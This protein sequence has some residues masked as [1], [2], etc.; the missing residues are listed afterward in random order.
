MPGEIANV[1]GAGGI[2]EV[3]SI[4][5]PIQLVKTAAFNPDNYIITLI[6]GTLTVTPRTITHTTYDLTIS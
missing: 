3:G 2:T 6:E 4:T 1:F 5:N